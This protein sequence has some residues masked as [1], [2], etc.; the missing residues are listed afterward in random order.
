[1][2][3]NTAGP[4]GAFAH[5]YLKSFS[6]SKI[7]F[8]MAGGHLPGEREVQFFW[9]ESTVLWGKN[10]VLFFLQFLKKNCFFF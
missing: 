10:T 9:G 2:E 5:V 7:F 6:F 4:T 8:T 1:M 3:K